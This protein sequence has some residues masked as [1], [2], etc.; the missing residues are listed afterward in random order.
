MLI[1]ISCIN[2]HEWESVSSDLHLT[3]IFYKHVLELMYG[4]CLHFL[5]ANL[6]KK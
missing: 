4:Y 3:I 6:P 2:K 5:V 1:T